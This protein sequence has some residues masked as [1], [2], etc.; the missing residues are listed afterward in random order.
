MLGTPNENIESVQI[1]F[2]SR[3]RK[4]GS[5]DRTRSSV[6]CDNDELLETLV[7]TATKSTT[8]RPSLRERKR[9]RNVDRKSRKLY[10]QYDAN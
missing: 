3:R 5:E 2:T 4:G 10:L 7:K 8:V 1:S 6:T 9:A